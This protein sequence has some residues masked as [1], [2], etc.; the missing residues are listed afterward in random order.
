[1]YQ[2]LIAEPDRIL[3]SIILTEIFSKAFLMI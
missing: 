3:P 1:M 2:I